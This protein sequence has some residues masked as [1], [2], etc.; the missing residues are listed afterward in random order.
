MKHAGWVRW[1]VWWP[2]A[3]LWRLLVPAILL[4]L[5][6]G[7]VRTWQVMQEERQQAITAQNDLLDRLGAMLVQSMAVQVAMGQSDTLSLLA[8]PVVQMNGMAAVHW[9]WTRPNGEVVEQS[10]QHADATT[11]VGQHVSPSMPPGAVAT[12]PRWFPG[13]IHLSGLSRQF[14]MVWQGRTYG[15]LVL[16]TDPTPWI[17]FAWLR[18][19]IQARMVVVVIAVLSTLLALLLRSSL[20]SLAQLGQAAQ[21][22]QAGQVGARVEVAG[23]QEIRQAG[24]AFNSMAEQTEQLVGRLRRARSELFQEKER[25]EITLASIAE[26]VIAT[27]AKAQVCFINPV[28][29]AL[30][31]RTREEVLGQPLRLVMPVVSHNT[32]AS[33]ADPMALALT[34][35]K[36]VKLAEHSRLL[37]HGRVERIIEGS[38][39]PVHDGAGHVVGGV[40]VFRDVTERVA[41]QQRMAWQM[42]HDAL[43]DLPNRWLIHDR[44]E[45]GVAQARRDR[46]MLAVCFVDL[47][48]FKAINDQHGHDVGD[49]VL[50]I[51]AQRLKAAVRSTD[52]VGRLG[53]D[54][55]VLLLG[56]L[57]S[58]DEL[59]QILTRLITA[60]AE[61]CLTEKATHRLGASVG[62]A[63]LPDEPCEPDTLLRHADQAMYRAKALG[64]HQYRIFED[65]DDQETPV[66]LQRLERL[67][68]ALHDGEFRLLFQPKVHLG[69][70]VMTGVEALLRWQH[71][72]EG[73]LLPLEFLPLV[74]QHVLD[75]QITQWVIE[76]VIAQQQRW[77]AQGHAWPISFNMSCDSL[78][79]PATL[80]CLKDR[81]EAAPDVPPA[82]L[83]IELLESGA[84]NDLH[85]LGSLITRYQALGIKVALGNFGPGAS[86]PLHL[87]RL[88]A[89]TVKI[90]PS[91][92]HSMADDPADLALVESL[93]SMVR[94]FG[95]QI[96]AEGIGTP[97]QGLLLMRLGCHH[98]QG[99]AIARPMSAE[100]IP[101]WAQTYQGEDSWRLW[102]DVTWNVND[103]PLLMA[104][105]D[106]IHWVQQIVSA[107]QGVPLRLTVQEVCDH[108]RCRFGQWYYGDGLQ[109]YSQLHAFK[110]IENVHAEIHRVGLEVLQLNADG[111]TEAAQQQAKV[112]LGM[113]DVVISHLVDLHRAVAVAA[114]PHPHPHADARGGVSTPTSEAWHAT[115]FDAVSLEL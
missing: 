48:G 33:V 37:G 41:M 32:R 36:V 91:F 24:E 55:F 19:S 103:F 52:S 62:V 92:I 46:S 16:H 54:E 2:K 58:T 66:Q 64:G 14:P 93:I 84:Q 106:H 60:M 74:Q 43:T 59:D 68:Q 94:I 104:Q 11:V 15:Q 87:K 101:V 82:M 114:V 20:R 100:A 53:G 67:A 79:A 113:R 112:L 1:L 47:D 35:A 28:A 111:Q 99:H 71:P 6:A 108:T 75:E 78:F 29:E 89:D 26:A 8:Q 30:L 107:T 51:V 85:R 50:V 96:I 12:A 17:D 9:Q 83:E 27:D 102:A 81:L 10:I 77:M 72:E 7:S 73:L 21:S 80:T 88:P 18:V 3:L 56:S 90:D 5:F 4:I 86:S 40:V 95:R 110:A 76:E 70:G 45:Q 63:L 25:L 49:E 105:Q 61:P 38:V 42:G 109:R 65:Q 22:L 115:V 34:T 69:G 39:A 23:C 44:L 31:G 13:L 97:E 57:S 98:G